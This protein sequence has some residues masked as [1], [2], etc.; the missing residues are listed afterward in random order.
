MAPDDIL[1]TITPSSD[2]IT[3]ALVEEGKTLDREDPFTALTLHGG[4]DEIRHHK[5]QLETND[6][7]PPEVRF[8]L[9]EGSPGIGK[10]TLCWEL[11]RQWDKLSSLQHFQIILLLR[12]R[13]E[14]VQKLSS[15]REMFDHVD[16][17]LCQAMT[18]E[19]CQNDGEGILLIFDGFDELPLSIVQDEKKW[20]MK[21][22]NGTY[23]CSATRIV[24]SR[25]SA[26]HHKKCFKQDVRHIEIVGFVGSKSKKD[27]AKSAFKFHPE[28]E[29][30]FN[31]FIL[32][33]PIV[34][35]LMEIPINCVITAQVFKDIDE[36]AA[37]IP[38]TMTQLYDALIRNL[39]KRH[40]IRTGRWDEGEDVTD[41]FYDKPAI[42]TAFSKLSKLAFKGLYHREIQISFSIEETGTN[43]EH[44]GLIMEVRKIY[45]S[46]GR[47]TLYSFLH[48]TIQEF[49]AAWHAAHN[50]YVINNMT[51][52]FGKELR[53]APK[54]LRKKLSSKGNTMSSQDNIMK[55]FFKQ[56]VKIT[57]DPHSSHFVAFNMFLAG[58]TKS[59]VFCKVWLNKVPGRYLGFLNNCLHA[60]N[61]FYEAQHPEDAL[62]W[63]LPSEKYYVPLRNA[64]DMYR[65]GYTLVQCAHCMVR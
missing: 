3:L 29:E 10:S 38:E 6:I 52:K 64:M 22:L 18:E 51:Y 32:S 40:M 53:L 21:L 12:L 63:F 13:D 47:K 55:A 16:E 9:I 59:S 61:C 1:S 36:S 26:L 34:S 24:T 44:L 49:L 56:T 39:V 45:L 27:F 57:D 43:F 11:C 42:S 58:L 41:S 15:V 4:A 25:P 48:L 30:K 5:S 23:L 60:S 37:P 20:I 2:F 14:D 19:V 8:V 17:R 31:T 54:Q 65:F 46:K 35:S 33:N 28:L 7:L 50:P 62:S